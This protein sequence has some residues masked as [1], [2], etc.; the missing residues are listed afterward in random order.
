MLESKARTLRAGDAALR[1]TA[2]EN[3]LGDIEMRDQ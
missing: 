2:E 1:L 3:V